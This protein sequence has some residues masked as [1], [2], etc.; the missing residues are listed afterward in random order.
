VAVGTIKQVQLT[1]RIT[2]VVVALEEENKFI[3]SGKS[4]DM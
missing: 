2:N 4:R 1:G 3:A